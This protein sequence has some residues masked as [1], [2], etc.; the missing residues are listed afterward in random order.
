MRWQPSVAPTAR[1]KRRSPSAS[2]CAPSW[3][4]RMWMPRSAT[5]VKPE[6]L[7]GLPIGPRSTIVDRADTIL[8]WAGDL[9]EEFPSLYL[10]VRHAVTELGAKLVVVHPRRSGLDDVAT[11]P[12]AIGPATVESCSAS[13]RATTRSTR[14][15]QPA[16]RRQGDRNHRAAWSHRGL[17]LPGGGGRLCQHDS[18][19]PRSCRSRAVATCSVLSTWAW[20]PRCFLVESTSTMRSSRRA[21]GALGT[22]ARRRRQDTSASWPGSR[23]ASSRLALMVGADPVRDG[24]D[25]REAREALGA[26]SSSCRSTCSLNDSNQ[27]ASVILPVDGF[28]ETEGTVTNIEGRVQKVNRIVPGPG[29]SRA[30]WSILDEL[31]VR[32]GGQ[33]GAGNAAAIAKEIATVAPAYRSFNWDRSSGAPNETALSCQTAMAS[34][35]CSTSRADPGPEGRR[36]AG[37]R[38]HF[39]RVLYDGGHSHCAQPSLAALAPEPAVHL[40]PRDA[41]AMA[42]T[43]GPDRRR[44]R[45]RRLAAPAAAVD[46]TMAEGAAYIPSEPRLHMGVWRHAGRGDRKRWEVGE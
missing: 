7:V 1:T 22:A 4:R 31:S 25:P 44:G 42:L 5:S 17:G 27:Y 38:L 34:S 10:R 39:G 26:P 19:Q 37:S 24:R 16:W 20:R 36:R 11:R 9:K 12:C 28:A 6:L 18:R 40:H 46:P 30:L 45:R 23:L 8:L 3:S 15:S 41:S 32:M 2:S 35:R 14:S 43:R 21:R 29:Q 33:L 13:W